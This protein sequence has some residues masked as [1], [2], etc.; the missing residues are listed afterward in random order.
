MENLYKTDY[1]QWLGQ[2]R[3]LLANGQFD[4]LDIPNLLEAMD[5][6]MGDTT[7][8]LRSHLRVLLLHLLK[9]DYQ[10]RILKDSWVEDKVIHTWMPSIYNSR[11]EIKEHMKRN[12]SLEPKTDEILSEA[13][14]TAKRNAIKE[15]NKFIRIE[16]KRLN[17]NSI[18][19]ECLW[20][21][22]KI[23]DDDWLPEG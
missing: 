3:E 20:T 5:S 7:N 23:T 8:E 10:K 17:K 13:Y 6:E 16:N 14:L 9:Y 21:F 15:L 2:Q 12:L 1:T 4:Q 19:D 18:P 22:E 11:M